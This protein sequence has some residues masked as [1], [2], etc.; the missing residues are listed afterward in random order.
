MRDMA[1]ARK[2]VAVEGACRACGTTHDLD[3]AHVIPRSRVTVGGEDLRNIVPLCR[4]CHDAQHAGRLE[5]LPLLRRDEQAYVVELVG[6]GEAY[7]RTTA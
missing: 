4:R 7:R 5:L 1:A 3:P 2:K 6:L